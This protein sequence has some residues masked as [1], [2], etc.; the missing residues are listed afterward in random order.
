MGGIF[1]EKLL[2]LSK[3]C[4][5]LQRVSYDHTLQTLD[6]T[7]AVCPQLSGNRDDSVCARPSLSGGKIRFVVTISPIDTPHRCVRPATRYA[8]HYHT[9]R[10]MYIRKKERLG[11]MRETDRQ[12]DRKTDRDRDR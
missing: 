11:E 5:R 4:W 8:Q 2:L 9:T 1:D 6:K 10:E 3:R 12:T 7:S